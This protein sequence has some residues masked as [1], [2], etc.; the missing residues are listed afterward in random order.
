M[1]KKMFLCSS[2][3]SLQVSSIGFSIY[4]EG[5]LVLWKCGADLKFGECVLWDLEIKF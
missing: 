5:S 2:K 1:Y 3:S 4:K